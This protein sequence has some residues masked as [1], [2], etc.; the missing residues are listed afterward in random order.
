MPPKKKQQPSWVRIWGMDRL[1]KRYYEMQGGVGVQHQ[2]TERRRSWMMWISQGATHREPTEGLTKRNR[3]EMSPQPAHMQWCWWDCVKE[4]GWKKGTLEGNTVRTHKTALKSFFIALN[5][6]FKELKISGGIHYLS[7]W[8]TFTLLS[9][10]PHSSTLNHHHELLTSS[11]KGQCEKLDSEMLL[12]P[13]HVQSF[14]Q[15]RY[16]KNQLNNITKSC[17]QQPVAIAHWLKSILQ[18]PL[19]PQYITCKANLMTKPRREYTLSKI[20]SCLHTLPSLSL[21]LTHTHT[22]IHTHTHTCSSPTLQWRLQIS[23][24]DLQGQKKSMKSWIR[25]TTTH[26]LPACPHLFMPHTYQFK[27]DSNTPS[28]ISPRMRARG[29]R[30][31]MFWGQQRIKWKPG[32][33][34]K[35]RASCSTQVWCVSP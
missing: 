25:A 10:W 4:K 6:L 13:H 32:G 31:N 26:F 2:K 5:T 12:I 33:K 1:S 20:L 9:S 14:F 21:S 18:D 27:L 7:L 19:T 28:V 16:A 23:W 15:S 22:H 35:R 24:P 29:I 17:I 3:S 30:A 8:R 11:F 34:C